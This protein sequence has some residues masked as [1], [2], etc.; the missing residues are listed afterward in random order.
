MCSMILVHSGLM[1]LALVALTGS[2][3]A[4]ILFLMQDHN[5]RNKRFGGVFGRLP[6]LELS[7][8]IIFLSLT[9]GTMSLF[10][11]AVVGMMHFQKL[12]YDWKL[13]GEPLVLLSS[14]MILVYFIIMS[15]GVGHLERGKRYAYVSIMAYVVLIFVLFTANQAEGML[16]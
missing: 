3:G 11:G 7:S 5:V 14:I 12:A 13:L 15:R 4:A 6:S 1:G 16:H 9:V 2:F 10:G 8:R